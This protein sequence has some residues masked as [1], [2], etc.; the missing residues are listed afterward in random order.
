MTTTTT[1]MATT[2]T[3][4]TTTMATTTTTMATTMA[5]TK[6][7]QRLVSHSIRFTF[8]NVS[9]KVQARLAIS[10]YKLQPGF[11]SFILF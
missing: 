11:Q 4:M 3:T 10:L 7:Q 2:A 9:L 5:T 8:A 1:T 6:L